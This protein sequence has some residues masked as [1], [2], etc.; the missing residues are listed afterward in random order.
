MSK[1][2]DCHKT[3]WKCRN[4]SKLFFHNYHHYISNAALIHTFNLYIFIIFLF[5]RTMQWWDEY[6]LL[7]IL[8]LPSLLYILLNNPLFPLLVL[9]SDIYHQN[10][11]VYET[12]SFCCTLFKKSI[13]ETPTLNPNRTWD[14]Y[15]KYS[16]TNQRV[17]FKHVLRVKNLPRIK[18]ST[19]T[20]KC[21]LSF[22]RENYGVSKSNSNTSQFSDVFLVT[23]VFDT[24]DKLIN[25]FGSILMA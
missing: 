13:F 20:I 2:K 19:L 8:L 1:S 9:L 6:F 10:L 23:A 12:I 24:I 22:L 5:K 21:Y 4:F 17:L 15:M 3:N 16:E 7:N 25:V 18:L 11:L 14:Y